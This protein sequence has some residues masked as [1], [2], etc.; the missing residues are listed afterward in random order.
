MWIKNEHVLCTIRYDCER[1]ILWMN[2]DFSA[3]KPY[4]LTVDAT[5]IYYY[6][7]ENAC[8]SLDGDLLQKEEE[9]ALKVIKLVKKLFCKCFNCV[10]NLS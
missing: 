3:T 9:L 10:L 8:E 4:S 5:K 2:P 7:I 6:R 1:N